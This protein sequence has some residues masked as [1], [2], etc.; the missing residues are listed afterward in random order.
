MITSMT[1]IDPKAKIPKEITA[2]EVGA[3]H[4]GEQVLA[5]QGGGFM[6]PAYIAEHFQ[7]RKTEGTP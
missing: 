1:F 5:V 2:T 4:E 6:S 7:V 3:K